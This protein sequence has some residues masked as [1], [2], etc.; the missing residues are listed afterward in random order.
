MAN[1]FINSG[2]CRELLTQDLAGDSSIAKI[3]AVHDIF[4][5]VENILIDFKDDIDGIDF[6]VD[7]QRVRELRDLISK[8]IR[9]NK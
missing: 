3:S 4:G 1:M 9:E 8:Q 7:Q 5:L 6:P 2:T